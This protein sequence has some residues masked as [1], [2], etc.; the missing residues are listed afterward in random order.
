MSRDM[1][2][3][4]G[5]LD[6]SLTMGAMAFPIVVP[7]PV[8]KTTTCDPAPTSPGV[9]SYASVDVLS[10]TSLTDFQMLQT[11][12]WDRG[13]LPGTLDTLAR[14]RSQVPD[15]PV[16]NGEVC[17][18]GIMGASGSD[19]QRFLFWAQVLG[20]AAGHTYGAQGLWAMND[21]TFVGHAG[22]WGSATWRE[23]AALPGGG[24]VGAARRWLGRS[25]AVDGG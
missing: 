21:G 19:I 9:D 23:A 4:T 3:Y 16:I 2:S 18:E 20:G 17:Y 24:H 13:S 11:G 25:A 22:D 15:Q 6:V 1:R 14:V 8:V 7:R 5:V 12:H 10:D